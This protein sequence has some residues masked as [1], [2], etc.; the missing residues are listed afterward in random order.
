MT[1]EAD[2]GDLVY[3][4]SCTGVVTEMGS[5]QDACMGGRSRGLDYLH[6]V[7]VAGV[8]K[9]PPSHIGTQKVCPFAG[10]RVNRIHMD[11]VACGTGHFPVFVQVKIGRD[12]NRGFYSH[13]M[14]KDVSLSVTVIAEGRDIVPEAERLVIVKMAESALPLLELMRL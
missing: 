6:C 2:N 5:I 14:G 7:D 10:L 3:G 1:S 12:L 11:S 8:A 13:Y 4:R 9:F